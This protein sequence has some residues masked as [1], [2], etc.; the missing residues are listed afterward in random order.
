MW[1]WA[2]NSNEGRWLASNLP[3]ALVLT[4]ENAPPLS[5]SSESLPRQTATQSD[6]EQAKTHEA[7]DVAL[8]SRGWGRTR[9]DD[10]KSSASCEISLATTARW[11]TAERTLQ[12]MLVRSWHDSNISDKAFQ[13]TRGDNSQNIE[14]PP[15]QTL[16]TVGCF[17]CA[18]RRRLSWIK[19]W[20]KHG[21]APT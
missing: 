18:R 3:E 17:Q 12:S 4:K 13:E 5:W 8:V 2:P 9:M 11:R 7:Q 19:W 6:T 10:S 1:R 20:N 15:E 16:S 14:G 21:S